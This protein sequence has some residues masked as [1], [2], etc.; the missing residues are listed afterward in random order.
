MVPR[1]VDKL[2]K[3]LINL[4]KYVYNKGYVSSKGGNLSGVIGNC[5]LIKMSGVSLGN[6][7][8]KHL[9]IVKD[10][11]EKT[12]VDKASIDYLIHR[13]IYIKTG[14]KYVIHCHPNPIIRYTILNPEKDI[15]HPID[16]EGSYYLPEGIPIVKG[17]H[18]T[19]YKQIGKLAGNYKVIVESGHGIYVWGN[20]PE[21]VKNLTE[22]SVEIFNCLL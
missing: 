3:N 14:A 11:K 8:P 19:I 13:E 12:Q 20:S 18:Q 15:V 2:L 10:F 17:E 9:I 5:M 6:L 22:L 21:E 1:E 4:S 7:K 16:L